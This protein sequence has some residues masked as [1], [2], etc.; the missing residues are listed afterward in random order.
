MLVLMGT[1]QDIELL[2]LLYSSC[3]FGEKVVGNQQAEKSPF[4]YSLRVSCFKFSTTHSSHQTHAINWQK[5]CNITQAMC[6]M[7]FSRHFVIFYFLSPLMSPAHPPASWPC[8]LAGE[9]VFKQ[10]YFWEIFS[11]T[12]CK[13]K[14]KCELLNSNF[15]TFV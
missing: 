12:L 13:D 6:S 11:W 1:I 8:L 5:L 3:S 2:S 15:S 7:D 9:I 14:L 10:M 4:Y